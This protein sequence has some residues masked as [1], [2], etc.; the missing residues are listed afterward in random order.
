MINRNP[1]LMNIISST[2]SKEQTIVIVDD[3]TDKKKLPENKELSPYELRELARET[4]NSDKDNKITPEIKKQL[5]LIMETKNDK[6]LIISELQK[7]IDSIEKDSQNEKINDIKQ[8]QMIQHMQLMNISNQ[9]NSNNNNNNNN[10]SSFTSY[11]T[12]GLGFG[13]GMGLS[14]MLLSSFMYHPYYSYYYG[15]NPDYYYPTYYDN[16]S[17]IEENYFIDNSVTDNFGDV[18]DASGF[19][20]FD[21]S[22]FSDFSDF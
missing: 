21:F 5:K 7:K 15:F 22:D 16:T 19:S 2:K 3:E 13:M 18:D 12:N 11:F 14:T 20:D 8:K 1:D 17:I 4:I 10:S 6:D 9:L